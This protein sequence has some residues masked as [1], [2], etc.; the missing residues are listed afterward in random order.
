MLCVVCYLQGLKTTE[1]K[2]VDSSMIPVRASVEDSFGYMAGTFP[3]FR[4]KA[5]FQLLRRSR[6]VFS[7]FGWLDLVRVESCWC[8]CRCTIKM[9]L[10]VMTLFLNL[11]TCCYGNQITCLFAGISTPSMAEYMHNANT[12]TLLAYHGI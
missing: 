5:N 4:N 7:L 3:Y 11:K 10:I 8:V 6:C 2:E 1:E 12:G 9:Q